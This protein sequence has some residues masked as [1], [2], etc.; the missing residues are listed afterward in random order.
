MHNP[1]IIPSSTSSV[2]TPLE[3]EI[4]L[5]AWRYYLQ[6]LTSPDSYINMSFYF[7][8]QACLQRRVFYGPAAYAIFPNDFYIMVGEP[9]VGKGLTISP[10]NVAMRYHK[11]FEQITPVT[12]APKV[13]EDNPKQHTVTN[14]ELDAFHKAQEELLAEKRKDP[15]WEEPLLYPV[16]AD[17][18]SY[19]R[20]VQ[21][22]ARSI[23][24]IKPQTIQPEAAPLVGKS[25]IYTHCSMASILQELS[26][27]FQENKKELVDY[28]LQAWDCQD[29]RYE[30]VHR[31][32]DIVQN[33]CYSLLA[34]TTPGFMHDT[35][36]D[37]LVNE[38]FS[39]RTIFIVEHRPRSNHYGIKEFTLG[40]LEALHNFYV[41]MRKLSKLFGQIKLTPEA[42][43]FTKHY[44]EEE[45][46]FRRANTNLTLTPYYAK[47][48]LHHLKLAMGI[49]FADSLSME[50]PL[51]AV[52]GLA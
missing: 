36:S 32:A 5:Q 49:H 43:A 3:S 10:V 2:W 4:N 40:Q 50:I 30:T 47:K 11:L 26:S 24:R 34:G 9:G 23:R 19:Q 46:P 52:Q 51:S 37:R 17:A 22:N 16:P 45:L 1:A 38:G 15:K 42:L 25:G 33:C 8:I 21:A 20:L 48:N 29:Y 18:M 35:F 39:A 6:D 7:M 13:I 44:F 41:H 31:E 28:L 14:A 12:V 27:L